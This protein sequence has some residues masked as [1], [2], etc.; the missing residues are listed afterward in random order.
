MKE[1]IRQAAK[2]LAE[3]KKQ[4]YKRTKLCERCGKPYVAYSP[5][6]KYCSKSCN[7]LAVY[8]RKKAKVMGNGQAK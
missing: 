8:Y 7:V 5:R 3:W 6:S 1:E 4:I 2:K